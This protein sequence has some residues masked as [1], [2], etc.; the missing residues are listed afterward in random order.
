MNNTEGL[1]FSVNAPFRHPTNIV[2]IALMTISFFGFYPIALIQGAR[3]HY[4]YHVYTIAGGFVIALFGFIAGW[5]SQWNSSSPSHILLSVLGYLLL[6]FV[7][8]HGALAIY[9]HR[10]GGFGTPTPANAPSKTYTRFLPDDH[11][12]IVLGWIIVA[13][14]YSYLVVAALVFTESC[15]SEW[16]AQC[17]MPVAIGS[18]FL[19]YGSAILLHLLNAFSLPRASTPEYYESLILTLWG[20]VCLVMSDLPILGSDWHA[21][22]MGLL[23]FAGGVF[24]IVLSMQTWLPSV[25]ERNIINPLVVCLTGRAIITGYTQNDPFA[26]EVHTTLGA[27]LPPSIRMIQPSRCLWKTKKKTKSGRANTNPLTA[28]SL[29][30]ELCRHR[31]AN[32]RGSLRR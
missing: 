7:L 26:A 22:N 21:L 8:A 11:A 4:R 30:R 1:S 24:S 14:A 20:I 5:S 13:L 16:S 18:G 32:I 15:S 12:L 25:R 28:S 3:R 17:L 19:W 9:Q 29:A 2:H 27:P 31:H 6:G 10:F 23:W